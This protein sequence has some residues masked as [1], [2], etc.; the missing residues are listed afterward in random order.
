MGIEGASY[1]VQ[2]T[3]WLITQTNEFKAAVPIAGIANLVSYNYITYYNQYEEMEFAQFLH[4]ATLMDVAWDRSAL[5]HVAASPTPP[6]LINGETS[7]HFP[8]AEPEQSFIA[9]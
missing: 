2:L 3:D 1:G 8:M 6:L 7:N 9:S 4:Q 5:K